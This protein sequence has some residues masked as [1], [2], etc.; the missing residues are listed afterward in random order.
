MLGEN[1]IDACVLAVLAGM[2]AA[3][4]R[5]GGSRDAW[6]ALQSAD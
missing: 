4:V 1:S 3:S 5:R 6:T 2:A